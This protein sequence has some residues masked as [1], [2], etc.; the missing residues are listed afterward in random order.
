MKRPRLPAVARP[1]VILQP[2][3]STSRLRGDRR[4]IEDAQS[5]GHDALGEVHHPS[6]VD[7][8]AGRGQRRHLGPARHAIS[9][10]RRSGPPASRRRDARPGPTKAV[11]DA[12]AIAGGG[13][14]DT[15]NQPSPSGTGRPIDTPE[16]LGHAGG[17]FPQGRAA[18]AQ[19]YR[20]SED[21]L[22][23]PD[24]RRRDQRRRGPAVDRREATHRQ[25]ARSHAQRREGARGSEAGPQGA[26]HRPDDL[27]ARHVHRAVAR[28]PRRGDGDRPH[29]GGGDPRLVLV[30]LAHVSDQS[31][32]DSAVADRGALGLD[33]CR[34][35]D[36][37]DGARGPGHRH[38]RG[39]RRCD[40]RRREY[41][42]P[43]ASQP[44]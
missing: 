3:S 27:P 29:L 2:L 14:V 5:D 26:G 28:Q 6:S 11:T 24:R 8:R 31:R 43:V 19:G 44:R 13:F 10:A 40:H 34:V 22:P 16:D 4:L 18:V 15:A 41:R 17:R 1:P 30:R 32:C 36:Q 20:R 38:G 25:H 12:S 23:A 21:R 35:H 9:S 33:L 37:H 7:G 42:A 39:G